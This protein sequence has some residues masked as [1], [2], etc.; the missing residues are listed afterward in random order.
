MTA[1]YVVEVARPDNAPPPGVAGAGGDKWYQRVIIEAYQPGQRR[2]VTQTGGGISTRYSYVNEGMTRD[3]RSTPST[4]TTPF[5]PAPRCA[6]REMWAVALE[7]GAPADAVAVI[8]YDEEGYEFEINI[9][10]RRV[11]L[12]FDN[13]CALIE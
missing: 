1:E 3:V 2:T 4:N 13:D 7:R 11:S 9:P 6:F 10:D 12:D 8:E 5:L